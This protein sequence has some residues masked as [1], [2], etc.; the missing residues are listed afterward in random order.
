MITCIKS[1]HPPFENLELMVFKFL[2]HVVGYISRIRRFL[3]SFFY[4]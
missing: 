4:L 2:E 3:I 1:S